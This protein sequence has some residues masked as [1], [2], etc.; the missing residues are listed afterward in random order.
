M[1]NVAAGAVLDLG[2]G[3]HFTGTYTGSGAGVVQLSQGTDPNNLYSDNVKGMVLNFP[4]NLFQWTGGTIGSYQGGNLVTNVGTINL[5]GADIQDDPR[6][7]HEHPHDD[8]ERRGR[9]QHRGQQQ[10]RQLSPTRPGRRT[11]CKATP[12]LA[13]AAIPSTTWACSRNRPARARVSTLSVSFNN[14]GGTV[15]VDS[16]TLQI[17]LNQTSTSTGGVFNV[18]A[19][20]VLDLGDGEH[21]TGTYTGSGAGVVQLSQGTDPNNLYTDNQTG[22]TF[23]FPGGLFQ[24]TG[25]TIG[26]YQGG[27]LITNVGTI[28]LS[29][30]DNK[31]SLAKFTNTG[32]MIQTGTGNFDTGSA[33][34]GGS[35]TNAAG[36][37]Y[38]LQSDGGLGQG[39]YPFTNAGLL[40]KTTGTGT[41]TADVT[42][43]NTGTITVTTGTLSFYRQRQ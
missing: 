36:A 21:F 34:S 38:D 37:T 15:E 30:A 19:G 32:T 13:R 23:N 33:N 6:R 3:E 1:F 29:G 8:P 18:A 42:L 26:S 2:D 22:A 28:N 25:G 4:G 17:P 5:S 12:T 10:R 24:W 20:A 43:T 31:T 9:L 41:S 27:Q 40:E 11:T 16:G 7:V 14:Q 39:S 35:F